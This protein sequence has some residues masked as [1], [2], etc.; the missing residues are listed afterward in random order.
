M[1]KNKKT[2]HTKTVTQRDGNILLSLRGEINM[3]TRCTT[4]NK[5]T[6]TR[7]TKHKNSQ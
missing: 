5:R 3:N 2:I 4:P 6:Y 1:A 7:K